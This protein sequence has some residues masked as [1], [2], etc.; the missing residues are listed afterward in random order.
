MVTSFR[1]VVKS[2]AVAGRTVNTL[3]WRCTRGQQR[4]TALIAAGRTGALRGAAAVT[5]ALLCTAGPEPHHSREQ[6]AAPPS[7]T[8]PEWGADG[9][10]RAL[11]GAFRRREQRGA[12]GGPGR[13]SGP[14]RGTWH[15]RADG[16][17]A[18]RRRGGGAR[19][20]GCGTY[21]RSGGQIILA[22][23]GLAVRPFNRVGRGW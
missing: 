22:R 6:V 11:G 8:G 19:K 13:A 17:G 4:P 23:G 15:A 7:R 21:F 1:R 5:Q 3:Q 12:G 20:K 10:G 14:L 16:R 18:Q 9:R 2:V